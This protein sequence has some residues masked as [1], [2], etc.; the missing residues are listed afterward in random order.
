MTI[1][2][3][4]NSRDW[5]EALIDAACYY[6]AKKGTFGHLHDAALHLAESCGIRDDYVDEEIERVKANS[7]DE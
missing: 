5:A 2:G 6:M 1:K 4:I 7:Y 3:E